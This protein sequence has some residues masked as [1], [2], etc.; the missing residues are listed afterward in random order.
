MTGVA[1]SQLILQRYLD[2]EALTLI[3]VRHGHKGGPPVEGLRGP[4]LLPQGH[5]QAQCLARRFASLPLDQIYCSDMARAYQTAEPIHALRPEV[6]F[7]VMPELREVAGQHLP[8]RPV[9]RTKEV[10]QRMAQ[11]RDA[12]GRFIQRLR[13]DHR[14]GQVVLAVV[15]GNL[16]RL[17][18]PT[19]AGIPPRRSVPISTNNSSVTLLSLVEGKPP[20]IQLANCT[21]HLDVQDV[22]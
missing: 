8:G 20:R 5:R 19:L 9:G 15:H 7:E 11:E 6:P 10:R 4:S 1:E 18:V 3:L 22:D 13:H 14:P 17:L 16:I 12:V 21:R 2:E